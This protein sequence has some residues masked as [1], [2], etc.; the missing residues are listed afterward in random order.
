LR[1]RSRD[2]STLEHTATA[3]KKSSM[4]RRSLSLFKRKENTEV[5][6]ADNQRRSGNSAR[7]TV[8]VATFSKKDNAQRRAIY[9]QFS[10]N[11][12]SVVRYETSDTTVRPENP[13]HAVVRVQASTVSYQD[14]ALRRGI[15]F[16]VFDPVTLPVTPGIDLVGHIASVGER[17]TRFRE[18]DRVAALVRTGGNARFVSV[19]ECDLFPVP[20]SL[21]SS[22]AVCMVSTYMTAFQSLKQVIGKDRSL[23]G[24]TLLVTG[25]LGPIAQAIIQLSWRAGA[26]KVYATAPQGRHKYVRSMLGAKPLHMD[27]H[28]WLPLVEGKMDVVMDGTCQDGF[29]S[30]QK[31]LK[32]KGILVCYAMADL[33]NKEG[34]GVFGAP[35]S[36]RWNH[37]KAT[38]FMAKTKTF[39]LWESHREN[40]QTFRNDLEH[41]FQLLKKREIKP[42]IAKRIALDDVGEA[43]LYLELGRARGSIVCLPWRKTKGAISRND[44]EGK[45]SDYDDWN[46]TTEK[47]KKK[48]G[49]T[50]ARGTR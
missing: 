32:E 35:L 30:S 24:K 18:G 34:M 41:L 11:P 16:N 29:E 40:P 20:R 19:D 31:A 15:D 47:N 21:D 2:D 3:S 42:H 8:S 28:E 38:Y 5:R 43:H 33:L 4:S 50:A 13:Y 17:C 23:S 25:A 6:E 26:E 49:K 9:H 44:N 22:E 36:A 45:G 14:C 27:P 48:R 7:D 10:D 39:D 12:R 37:A 46:E 1:G